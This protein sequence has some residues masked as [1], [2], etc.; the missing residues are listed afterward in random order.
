MRVMRGQ[1]NFLL[2][3][4]SGDLYRVGRSVGE[5]IIIVSFRVGTSKNK[6]IGHRIKETCAIMSIQVTYEIDHIFFCRDWMSIKFTKFLLF[7]NVFYFNLKEKY[8]IRK[9]INS[10]KRNIDE[11]NIIIILICKKLWSVEPVQQKIKLPSPYDQ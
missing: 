2:S 8:H 4:Q 7:F 3:S 11:I 1:L 10:K 5:I 6:N 9:N